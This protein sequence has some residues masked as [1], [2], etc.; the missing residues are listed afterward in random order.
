[1][2]LLVAPN[3][4]QLMDST[5]E[6]NCMYLVQEFCDGDLTNQ[7]KKKGCFSEDEALIVIK[8]VLSGFL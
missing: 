2:K 3:I 6:L 8:D 1:M 4:V 5:C 7:I